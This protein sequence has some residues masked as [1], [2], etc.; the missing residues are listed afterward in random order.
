MRLI[1]HNGTINKDLFDMRD[2]ITII[3]ILKRITQKDIGTTTKL[4]FVLL[5]RTKTR[6]A[7]IIKKNE[8]NDNQ[9]VYHV[10]FE[11][12]KE[13]EEIQSAID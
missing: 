8:G 7:L 10:K 2:K 12:D 5:I 6:E 13:N 11:M 9:E 4:E 3:M 1:K